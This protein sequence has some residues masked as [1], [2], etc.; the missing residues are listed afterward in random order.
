MVETC[1]SRGRRKSISISLWPF[2]DVK[3]PYPEPLYCTLYIAASFHRPITPYL[4]CLHNHL[5]NPPASSP[6]GTGTLAVFH[7]LEAPKFLWLAGFSI[8]F[9]AFRVSGLSS[10][11][12]ITL[13][14]CPL[15]AKTLAFNDYFYKLMDEHCT[16]KDGIRSTANNSGS[17]RTYL[18][19]ISMIR[20]D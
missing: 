2:S 7:L 4:P 17:I 6:F 14:L 9:F 18:T 12:Q 11:S 15:P 16:G 19:L 8:K 10:P 13:D 5:S 1:M 3:S 20:K